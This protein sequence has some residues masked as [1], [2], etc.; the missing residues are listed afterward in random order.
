MGRWLQKTG[1]S[2]ATLEFD[3]TRLFCCNH[4]L[5]DRSTKPS[6]H[7]DQRSPARIA[8]PRA[9]SQ[10]TKVAKQLNPELVGETIPET[11]DFL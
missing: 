1:I 8:G 5:G 4:H 3:K 2:S 11:R 10:G 6:Y 9:I 7:Q